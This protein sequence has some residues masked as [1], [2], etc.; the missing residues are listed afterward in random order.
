MRNTSAK[1]AASEKSA[2][3]VAHKKSAASGAGYS[4]KSE[5]TAIGHSRNAAGI[6]RWTKMDSGVVNQIKSLASHYKLTASVAAEILDV[7]PKTYSRY[8]ENAKPLSAQQKDRINIVESILR[9]GKRVLG[10]EIEVNRWLSRP[11]HSIENQRPIDLIVSESGRRRV[12]NV[13][14]QIEGGAY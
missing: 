1:K 10:S 6:Q 13:L 5:N 12:E 3:K 4:R 9:L 8:L 14:L 11:V 7:S 2:K